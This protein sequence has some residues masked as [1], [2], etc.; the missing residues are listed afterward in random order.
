VLFR[1]AVCQWSLL[2]TNQRIS[3][4]FRSPWIELTF[5]SRS[6][7]R[8]FERRGR[9]HGLRRVMKNINFSQAEEAEHPFFVLPACKDEEEE[10]E[11]MVGCHRKF[12]VSEVD[13]RWKGGL[14]T[15]AGKLWMNFIQSQSRCV[16]IGTRQRSKC[17]T[18]FVVSIVPCKPLSDWY[19]KS[20]ASWVP[21][22]S[23]SRRPI[24]QGR[25]LEIREDRTFCKS[26]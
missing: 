6:M 25:C 9:I 22:S 13:E 8:S 11:A 26:Q 20:C 24:H 5:P 4:V 12:G 14:P 19:N 7:R 23:R 2:F 3:C 18:A 16:N 17:K 10:R 1:D 21:K 15:F